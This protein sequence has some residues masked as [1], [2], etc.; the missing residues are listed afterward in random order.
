MDRYA[1]AKA[2]GISPQ[3]VT[4]YLKGRSEPNMRTLPVILEVFQAH[5]EIVDNE[6]A[7]L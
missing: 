3:M 7:V 2:A 4:Y 6:G 1:L 5:I